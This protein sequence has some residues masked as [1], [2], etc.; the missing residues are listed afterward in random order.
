MTS[1][2]TELAFAQL[3][4]GINVDFVGKRVTTSARASKTL[5]EFVRLAIMQ[6]WASGMIRKP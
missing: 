1:P 5:G 2:Q 6:F 4:I 3:R